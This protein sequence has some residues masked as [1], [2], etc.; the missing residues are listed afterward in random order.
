MDAELSGS[1]GSGGIVRSER[2]GNVLI[3]GKKKRHV[4]CSKNSEIPTLKSAILLNAGNGREFI[5]SRNIMS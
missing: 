3:L 2:A 5:T 1:K 4:S